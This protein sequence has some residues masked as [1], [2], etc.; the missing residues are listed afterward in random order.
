VAP[1]HPIHLQVSAVSSIT[2][3][4]KHTD[5]AEHKHSAPTEA[6]SGQGAMLNGG[7]RTDAL[8]QPPALLHPDTML[9][10]QNKTPSGTK[11]LSV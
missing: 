2:K 5:A 8:S 1:T 3:V 7:V 11:E 10:V 6:G 4:A 9:P